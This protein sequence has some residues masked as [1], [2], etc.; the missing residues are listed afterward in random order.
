MHGN[1][2]PISNQNIKYYGQF[3]STSVDHDHSGVKAHEESE[4]RSRADSPVNRCAL[5]GL[6]QR[7]SCLRDSGKAEA[8]DRFMA[9]KHRRQIARWYGL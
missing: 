6:L 7:K 9:A 4:R 3:K 5:R 2:L 8:A 1:L